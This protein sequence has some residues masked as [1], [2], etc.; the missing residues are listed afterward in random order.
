MAA[1]PTASD[2]LK[3]NETSPQLWVGSASRCWLMVQYRGR[4]EA[5][6]SEAGTSIARKLHD[7]LENLITWAG[8]RLTGPFASSTQS[9]DG[10]L[11]LELFG[12]V[13]ALGAARSES[14]AAAPRATHAASQ[15]RGG[16]ATRTS[17][18]GRCAEI[19]GGEA[20][21]GA[22]ER[23]RRR[24]RAREGERRREEV[25]EV[26]ERCDRLAVHRTQR[27]RALGA[28]LRRVSH[29]VGH[30]CILL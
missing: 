17:R 18:P 14:A 12:S 26:G 5:S 1:I 19:M 13:V 3:T 11:I 6:A 16:A 29:G 8:L 9:R 15:R 28:V 30:H 4:F 24:E 20:R 21:K 7:G 27:R 23:E 22:R 10:E 2:R 25:R